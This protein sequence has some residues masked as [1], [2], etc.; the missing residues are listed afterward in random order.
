[1]FWCQGSLSLETLPAAI[2]TFRLKPPVWSCLFQSACPFLQTEAKGPV[3]PGA[4]WGVHGE[5]S[6]A[7]MSALGSLP[8][9][10]TTH[11]PASWGHGS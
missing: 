11:I 10:L 4:S 5:F 8:P 6:P 3:G 7:H 1:M 9:S 2:L